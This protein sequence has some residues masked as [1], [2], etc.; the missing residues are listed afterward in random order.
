MV[1]T[2]C[3]DSLIA[4]GT[5]FKSEDIKVIFATSMAISEPFPIAIETSAW[6]RAWLSL[7]PSPTMATTLPSLCSFFTKSYFPC[8]STSASK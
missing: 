6:A 4:C 8:G 5:L 2:V 7:M 3:L 1:R